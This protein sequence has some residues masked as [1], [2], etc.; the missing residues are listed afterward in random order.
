MSSQP[1]AGTIQDLSPAP[2][3]LARRQNVSVYAGRMPRLR[4]STRR[5]FAA[6]G[7]IA[8]IL[9]MARLMVA[10]DPIFVFGI[11][12]CVGLLIGL[13]FGHD[14][15]GVLIGAACATILLSTFVLAL[16]FPI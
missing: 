15:E 12:P 8:G 2:L 11:C 7:A 1:G 4:Y 3:H 16:L 14:A 6:V 13:A 10:Y 9:W 5:L